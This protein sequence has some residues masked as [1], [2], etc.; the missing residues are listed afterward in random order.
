MKRI[1]TL[2]T[3]LLVFSLTSATAQCCKNAAKPAGCTT[4]CTQA[5]QT[6]T[7][8]IK[9]YYFHATRRCATCMAVEDVTK[10]TLKSYNGGKVLF[11]SINSE[12]DSK[13]PLI[14]KFK[15]NGQTLLL[16]KGDKVVDLTNDAFLYARTSP[17]KFKGKLKATIDSLK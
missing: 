13:N 14:E 5:Q 7:S 12:E 17:D 1:I 15:V 2:F 9:A 4:P 6:S 11:Q 3:I 16:V 10:E 8:E